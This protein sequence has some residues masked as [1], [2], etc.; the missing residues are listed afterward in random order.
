MADA[1]GTVKSHAH[2]LLQQLEERGRLR[3]KRNA[4]GRMRARAIELLP[5]V[6]P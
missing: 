5:P 6:W 1:L 4:R 3:V 2:R